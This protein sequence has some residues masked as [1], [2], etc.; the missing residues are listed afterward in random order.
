[1]PTINGINTHISLNIINI[2]FALK[3]QEYTVINEIKK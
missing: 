3:S 1:M 2:T